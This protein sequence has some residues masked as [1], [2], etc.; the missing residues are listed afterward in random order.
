MR[1]F[2]ILLFISTLA[3]SANSS[4]GR[5]EGEEHGK[6]Q[7]VDQ[8][9]L[10]VVDNPV[11]KQKLTGRLSTV[12]S[13]SNYIHLSSAMNLG[14]APINNL[15]D[16]YLIH[17]PIVKVNTCAEFYIEDLKYSLPYLVPEAADLLK[18]I[19][20]RFSDS[21]LVKN[22]QRYKIKVTSLLRTPSTVAKLKRRNGNATE[23]S[24]HQYGTTFDIS[25]VRFIPLDKKSFL[26]QEKLKNTLAQILFELRND[27]K[28]Y[29]KYEVKQG[30]FHITAR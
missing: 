24:A 18:E 1:L 10:A 11:A 23:A 25:Y 30:C 14:I 19:G 4:C 8:N 6:K 7:I 12:F 26:G 20:K 5:A 28:C 16:I 27:N 3:F 29:V 17:K 22:G 2:P 21:V 13:D 15:G 9:A